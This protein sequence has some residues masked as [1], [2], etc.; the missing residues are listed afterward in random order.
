MTRLGPYELHAIETGRFGLDGGA[1]FGIVPKPL[2]EQKI[3][4]DEQNRIPLHMRC[5]LMVSEERR[6]LIDTGIGDT[7][8]GTKQE[9]IYAVDRQS[10]SLEASLA[11]RGVSR[12]EITDVILTHLHFDH[13]GG[14]T[15]RVAEDRHDVAFPNASFYVQAEHWSWATDP[16]PKE[17][18]SFLERNF[19]PIDEAKQLYLLDGRTELFPGVEVVPV[20]G[21]TRSQQIVKIEGENET[22]VYVADLLPTTHHLRP[23]WTM[24]Y[25]VEPL[26]TIDEKRSFLQKAQ[27]EEWN[28]FFEHDPEVEVASLRKTDRGMT[29]V[30]PRPLSEL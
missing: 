6:I 15:R 12:E 23:A 11:E 30:D 29:T 8:A 22:L 28:L 18:G 24:A 27:K 25:D 13:C 26:Q 7:F 20:D 16:N 4:P 5:L 3:A 10:A 1:M 17:S 21:H 19:R 9:K 14:S 2:W